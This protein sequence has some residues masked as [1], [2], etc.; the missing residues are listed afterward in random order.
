MTNQR[1]REWLISKGFAA[2]VPGKARHE[3]VRTVE[4]AAGVDDDD[5][6]IVELVDGR[7]AFVHEQTATRGLSIVTSD[8]LEVCRD[9]ARDARYNRRPSRIAERLGIAPREPSG[10]GRVR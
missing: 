7:F 6:T 8:S 1:A 9:A 4:S 10:E 5:A 2:P 3:H